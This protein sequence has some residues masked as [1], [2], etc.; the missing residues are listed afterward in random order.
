MQNYNM[1]KTLSV[2]QADEA[3]L[4]LDNASPPD[5]PHLEQK[6]MSLPELTPEKVV[7]LP[8]NDTLCR[9]ILQ[10]M[11]CNTNENYFT[12]TMGILHKN[13]INFNST[14]SSVVIPQI[15]IK[16]LL[17]ASH[18]SLGHIGAMKLYYFLKRLYNFQGMWKRI[19][20][21][22]RFCQ[23]SDHELIKTPLHQLT[24]RYFPNP[25]R[26]HIY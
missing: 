5:I 16:Y 14:F 8:K 10:H 23:M 21:Y 1:L 6:L 19:H 7:Q 17:H 18:D 9:N 4:S 26:S 20:Q 15:L 13:V 24:S 11:H 25:T 3:R 2:T 12:D 22:A